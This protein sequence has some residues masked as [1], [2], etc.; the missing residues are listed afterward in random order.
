MD[1]EITKKMDDDREKGVFWGKTKT[2]GSTSLKKP[3]IQIRFRLVQWLARTNVRT[4]GQTDG[5]TEWAQNAFL[6]AHMQIYKNA[7]QKQRR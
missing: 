3:S 2:A 7:S 1:V 6:F 4:D 5:L